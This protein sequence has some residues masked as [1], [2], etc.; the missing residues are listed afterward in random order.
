MIPGDAIDEILDPLGGFE[1]RQKE[2]IGL[3]K[4]ETF[5][6]PQHRSPVAG[7]AF[8]CRRCATDSAA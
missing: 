8:A 6:Q 5:A 1:A 3:G 2:R 7:T 4:P